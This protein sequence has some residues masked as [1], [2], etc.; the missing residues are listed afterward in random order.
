MS[1]QQPSGGKWVA[2]ALYGILLVVLLSVAWWATRESGDET[3]PSVVSVPSLPPPRPPS[4]DERAEPP[5]PLAPRAVQEPEAPPV[6]PSTTT[7]WP[8]PPSLSPPR[9]PKHPVS[10]GQ[11]MLLERARSEVKSDPDTA[12]KTLAEYKQAFP[13]SPVA[14][15]AELIHLEALLRL[16]RKQEAESLGRRLIAHDQSASRSVERLLSE[17]WSN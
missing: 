11:K 17:V 16:G 12:L 10:T 13:G 14:Q 8:A 5:L 7:P 2:R 3:P 6:E 1:A 15:E 9:P 4:V